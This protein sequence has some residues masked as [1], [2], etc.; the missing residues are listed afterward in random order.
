M[1]QVKVRFQKMQSFF[2]ACGGVSGN[3]NGSAILNSSGDDEHG[4]PRSHQ[5]S[6]SVDKKTLPTNCL[7][8]FQAIT[9]ANNNNYQI[10]NTL[11]FIY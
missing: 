8:H 11:R 3:A 10:G 4:L 1:D 5:R 2:N 7:V 9:H 6:Y